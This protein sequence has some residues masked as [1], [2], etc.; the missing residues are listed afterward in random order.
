VKFKQ[1]SLLKKIQ[2]I[3]LSFTNSNIAD[4][5]RKKNHAIQRSDYLNYKQIKKLHKKVKKHPKKKKIKSM[6]V[7][8]F[9]QRNK[10]NGDQETNVC[11]TRKQMYGNENM[12]GSKT[13]VFFSYLQN[14]SISFFPQLKR[15]NLS[16]NKN[17]KQ[18][19]LLLN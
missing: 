16:H 11:G 2:L 13:I 9:T 15:Q 7:S 19:I 6:K 18:D 12:C 17:A 14:K 5:E 10:M 4:L 8:R 1:K 3:Y